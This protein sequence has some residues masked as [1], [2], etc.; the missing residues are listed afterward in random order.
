METMI[1]KIGEWDTENALT[2]GISMEIC[3]LLSSMKQR[4]NS[5]ITTTDDFMDFQKEINEIIRGIDEC[6]D[7][8]GVLGSYA[9][10][11]ELF[12]NR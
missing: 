5:L 8:A 2:F 3:T 7:L 12:K 11:D 9:M 4:V 6:F 10:I 1:K